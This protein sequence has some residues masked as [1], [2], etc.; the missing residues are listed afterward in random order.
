MPAPN[1]DKFE[2]KERHSADPKSSVKG[3]PKKD[4]A[5]GK[6][7]MGKAGDE[8]GPQVLDKKDPNYDSESEK[9]F[10]EALWTLFKW[11]AHIILFIW[12]WVEWC[13][14]SQNQ[15]ATYHPTGSIYIFN[16]SDFRDDKNFYNNADPLILQGKE[17]IDID[18]ELDFTIAKAL[19]SED[20]Y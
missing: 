19:L 11:H 8:D 7:T 17:C 1:D 3:E 6:F 9:W 15:N 16:Y 5:G 20:D 12:I 2:R 13:T 14:R 10:E 4:G 18:D